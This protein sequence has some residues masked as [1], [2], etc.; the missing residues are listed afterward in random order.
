LSLPHLERDGDAYCATFGDHWLQGRTAYGGASAALALSAVKAAFADLPPLRS[1]QIA[2]VGP[3]LGEVRAVPQLLRR[4]KNSAFVGCDVATAEG[5]GLRTL[6]LFM[7]PRASSIDY[8]DL[9]PPDAGDPETRLIDPARLPQGFLTN[10]ELSRWGDDKAGYTRWV[11]LKD[12]AGLD[13][14]VELIAI[15]DALPPAA[16]ALAAAWAPVST[17]TWQLNLVTDALATRE[18]W[19]LISDETLHAGQGSS[20]QAM[21]IWNRDGIPVATATQSVALFI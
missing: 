6:F 11:R 8:L 2:F 14:E 19:W 10:F 15:A 20:S 17:T 7:T 16:M 18:G 5:L 21:T 3:L 13:P 4:G 1:A 12:R 9:P